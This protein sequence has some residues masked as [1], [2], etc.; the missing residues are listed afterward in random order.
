M[1]MLYTHVSYQSQ[2]K[3]KEQCQKAREVK[4]A[5]REMYMCTHTHTCGTV[6]DMYL[7]GT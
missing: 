6:H 5:D 4:R 7:L 1:Y 2:E 3:K